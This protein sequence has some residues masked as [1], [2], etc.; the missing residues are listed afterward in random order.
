MNAA[1]G[2]EVLVHCFAN[3]RASAFVYLYRVLEGNVAPE[4]AEKD[5]RA[6]WDDAAFEEYAHW[7]KF[8]DETLAA[9]SR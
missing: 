9:K 6:I 1:K 3:Y 4:E 8:I 7:R 2:K 5:M